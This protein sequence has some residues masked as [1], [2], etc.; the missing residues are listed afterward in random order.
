[1]KLVS[2]IREGIFI[3]WDAIWANK[4]R[5]VLATLGIVIGVVTVTSM[6]TA[7]AGL[8]AAFLK[9]I[10]ALGGDVFHVSRV[11]WL[12][13]THEKWLENRKRPRLT[14]REARQLA[15]RLTL[16][17]AVAPVANANAPVS[18]ENRASQTIGVV[19]TTQHYL[20]TA[21]VAL[22]E[23]RFLSPAEVEGGRPV[24]VLGAEI[25]ENLFPDGAALG[26][27]IRLGP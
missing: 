13:D 18:F 11:D 7:I 5:S 25:A 4:L 19:G 20:L 23:G 1:M 26:K 15:E 24:C 17:Q 6:A 16:V 27:R 2:E 12:T 3:G 10:S 8:H 21:G 9:S 14:L 22:E